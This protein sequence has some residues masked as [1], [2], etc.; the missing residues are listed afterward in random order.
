MSLNSETKAHAATRR[1]ARRVL[2]SPHAEGAEGRPTV[3]DV[4]YAVRSEVRSPTAGHPLVEPPSLAVDEV[5]RTRELAVAKLHSVVEGARA[6]ELSR[7]AMH[8]HS[9]AW[10]NSVP[11]LDPKAESVVVPRLDGMLQRYFIEG[12]PVA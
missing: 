9:L 7:A 5:Y 1:T 11:L 4:V 3:G 6:Y 8:P 10:L 2:R 12:I